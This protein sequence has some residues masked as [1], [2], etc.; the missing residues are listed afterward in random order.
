MEVYAS[1]KT[2]ALVG[3]PLSDLT[4]TQYNLMLIGVVHGVLDQE[5]LTEIQTCIHDF[6]SEATILGHAVEDF[7]H[8]Q[9]LTGVREAMLA[10]EGAAG[11][12]TDCT[13]MQDDFVTL[14][15]WLG[16]VAATTDLSGMVRHN[17][18]RNL[19]KLT[20]DLNKA[21]NE[22]AAETYYEFG[23]TIGEMLTIVTQPVPA[24]EML[25]F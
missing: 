21:K 2:S 5:G 9:W 16:G 3:Q 19:L 20:R 13:S 4:T 22:W 18:T 7:L 25:I 10:L 11:A 14:E 1:M 24:V 8:G 12:K 23:T 15:G 17:I 6:K